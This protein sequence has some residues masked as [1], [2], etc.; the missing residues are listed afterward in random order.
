MFKELSEFLLTQ[1]ASVRERVSLFAEESEDLRKITKLAY[2]EQ[3][4]R[5]HDAGMTSITDS[6]AVM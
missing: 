6:L 5:E 2:I 3:G 1:I 4:R